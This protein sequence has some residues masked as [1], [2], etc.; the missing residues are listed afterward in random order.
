MRDIVGEEKLTAIFGKIPSFHDAEV[1]SLSFERT[2]DGVMVTTVVHVFAM[3]P[4][5][6]PTDTHRAIKHTRVT[7]RFT[8]CDDVDLGGF[9]HQNVLSSLVISDNEQK[10]AKQPFSVRFGPCYG[11]EGSLTCAGIEVVDAVPW[12]PPHGVYAPK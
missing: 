4:I 6:V 10:N 12:V 1:W 3:A 5:L 2:A 11:L 8:D 9:N 7:F